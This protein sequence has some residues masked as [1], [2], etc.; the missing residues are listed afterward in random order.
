M[1]SHPQLQF[2][3]PY[4]IL[5]FLFKE[6]A[7]LRWQSLPCFF[8]SSFSSISPPFLLPL[9]LLSSLSLF[10]LCCPLHMK[11]RAPISLS[12]LVLPPAESVSPSVLPVTISLPW[13]YLPTNKRTSISWFQITLTKASERNNLGAK[14]VFQLLI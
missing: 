8:H 13:L 11:P 6:L 14:D 5:N 10:L 1:L 3:R 9:S 2:S 4:G 12:P 7:W